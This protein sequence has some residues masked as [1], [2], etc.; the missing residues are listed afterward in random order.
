MPT[1][2]GPKVE[3]MKELMELAADTMAFYVPDDCPE[4]HWL[5]LIGTNPAHMT[6]HEWRLYAAMDSEERERWWRWRKKAW[7]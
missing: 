6:K 7:S 4:D 1:D 2:I 3:T 5:H